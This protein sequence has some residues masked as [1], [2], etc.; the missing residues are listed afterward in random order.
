MGE[1]GSCFV[2]V[3]SW[4]PFTLLE[5]GSRIVLHERFRK[6]VTFDPYGRGWVL[7]RLCLVLETLYPFRGWVQNRLANK[8]FWKPV[9]FDPLWER[10]GP[11][12]FILVLETRTLFRVGP[13]L[14]ARL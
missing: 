4:K 10:L 12:S 11:V 1:V 3:W 6:P 7:S 8:W 9:T 14:R 2:Y 13:E 5:G